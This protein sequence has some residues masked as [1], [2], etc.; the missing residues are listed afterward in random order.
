MADVTSHYRLNMPLRSEKEVN[1][2]M[3]L[4]HVLD[5]ST[6]SDVEKMMHFPLYSPRQSIATFLLKYEIFKRIINIQGSIIECGVAYGSGLMSFATFSAIFEPVNHTR[7]IIGFDTFEGFPSLSDKD[8]KDG[9]P[10]AKIGGM[11]VDSYNEI[12]KCISIFDQNRFIGHINKVE[13]VKGDLTKT[14]PEYLKNNPHLVVALLYLDLDLYEPTKIAIETFLPRMPKGAIIAFDELNHPDWPGET[15]A[16]LETI[17]IRNLRIER[18]P[19]DSV[20]S[21]A[22]IG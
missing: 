22:V 12:M 6:L 18:F 20:R 14:A 9:D 1:S 16:L 19:F 21:F 10:N 11:N 3:N 8:N 5:E 7:K 2:V 15:L 17:G 4:A 13:L